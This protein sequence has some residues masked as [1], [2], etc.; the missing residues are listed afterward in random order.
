MNE[1]QQE[2][3]AVIEFVKILQNY[4]NKFSL[5]AIDIAYLSSST[6]TNIQNLINI[7]GSLEIERME[8]IAKAFNLHHY[9]FSNPR[10]VL[11]EIET[12]P[13][14]TQNRIQHRIINGP[15]VPENKK[16]LTINDKISIALSFFKVDNE[17]L[18][19]EIVDCINKTDADNSCD[20][21]LVGDRLKK[22]FINYAQKTTKEPSG[23][24]NAGGK[25]FYFKI[26]AEIPEEELKSA[27]DGLGEDWFNTYKKTFEDIQKDKNP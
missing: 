7:N 21:S 25:A 6:R 11:P 19:K 9:E 1:N 22:S 2:Y 17:F 16:S 27:K 4:M 10:Q 8:L 3:N 24:K 26:I 23:K 12:L 20:T 13:E 18:T 5:E 15:Y 14:K